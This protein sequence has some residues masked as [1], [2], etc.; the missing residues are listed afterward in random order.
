MLGEG[1]RLHDCSTKQGHH[2]WLQP[3]QGGDLTMKAP[4]DRL[5]V[6]CCCCG[7]CDAVEWTWGL[8]LISLDKKKIS[9][10]METLKILL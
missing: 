1:G 5:R 3:G 8:I 7:C 10:L 4:R 9:H 2:S 6:C